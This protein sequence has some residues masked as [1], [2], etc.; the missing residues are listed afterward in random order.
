MTELWEALAF[1]RMINRDMREGRPF[2]WAQSVHNF[3]ER[4]PHAP[5]VQEV[6]A[7]VEVEMRRLLGRRVH[8]A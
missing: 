7:R 3:V 4:N 5:F 6:R 2:D 8:D 1:R